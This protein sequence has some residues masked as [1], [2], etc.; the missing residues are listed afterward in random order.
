[1]P[2]TILLAGGTGFIGS[3]MTELFTAKGHTVRVLTRTPRDAGQFGWDLAAGAIDDRA[4]DGA[5][6]VINLAG[7]G[8]ADGR[9][10][11]ARKK[12]L[13]DSRVQS[14]QLLRNAFQRLKHYPKAYLSASGIGYY[15]N[16]GEQWMYETD[17]PA[18]KSFLVQC[19]AAWEQGAE[20]VGALGIRTVVLR[21][22]IVLDK[23][24]GALREI[25]KPLPFGIG[26]YFADGQAWYSWIHR[27]D[28]CRM[29]LWAAETPAVEGTFNAVSPHPA[30]NIDFTRAVAKAMKQPAIFA[31]VPAFGLRLVLGEMADTVLFSNRI[32]PEKVIQA[33]F[34][35]QYPELAGALEQIYGA[36][37]SFQVL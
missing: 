13:I 12:I 22:G 20:A 11:P 9:W 30:R 16:S 10:T 36:R 1:M 17:T 24:G 14:A 32:S 27:D 18:D 8:I 28:L 34:H 2:L 21:T 19:C 6:V 33:G 26:A 31:P 23:A 37:N 25:A 5:D 35:F 4:V 15:G 29:F 7:A 3:R